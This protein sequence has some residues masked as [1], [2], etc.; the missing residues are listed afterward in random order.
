MKIIN[1]SLICAFSAPVD[2]CFDLNNCLELPFQLKYLCFCH[3]FLADHV[4]CLIKAGSLS[5]T[6]YPSD[7]FCTEACF[8]LCA[9][10]HRLLGIS[11][12]TAVDG[13]TWTLMRSMRSACNPFGISRIDSC[14]KLSSILRVIHDCF[15]PVKEPH[16]NRDIV[17]D[18]IFN[19][20]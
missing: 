9:Q 10:L 7:S 5:P 14:I 12:P 8:K 20:T 4:T 3:C 19:S 6:N 11:N 17:R 2:V 1:S 13:L 18:V 15:E 16:T